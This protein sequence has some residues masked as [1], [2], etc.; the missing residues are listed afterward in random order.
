MISDEPFMKII[1]IESCVIGYHKEI[2]DRT[3]IWGNPTRQM[4]A[5]H[6]KGPKEKKWKMIPQLIRGLRATI[7]TCPVEL[8]V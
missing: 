5:Q 7:S 6:V 2:V 1:D 8:G 3:Q 4:T